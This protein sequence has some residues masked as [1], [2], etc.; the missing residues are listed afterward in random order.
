MI[1]TS[2]WD[3][4]RAWVAQ[5]VEQR[6]ENPRVGGSNPPPGTISSHIP[7]DPRAKPLRR[8][9]YDCPLKGQV[10]IIP[11]RR[12]KNAVQSAHQS[13]WLWPSRLSLLERIEPEP[14]A[15]KWAWLTKY[16]K[17]QIRIFAALRQLLR[18]FLDNRLLKSR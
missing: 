3:G 10:C 13:A 6:I 16:V 12:L 8:E 7:G 11:N 14:W 2:R 4:S 18:L 5:L 9:D 15:V 1:A 17:F